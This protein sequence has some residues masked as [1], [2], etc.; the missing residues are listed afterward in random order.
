MEHFGKKIWAIADGFIP[1]KSNGPAPQMLSHD[2]LCFLNV[3]KTNAEVKV[4]IY[5]KDRPPVGPYLLKVLAERTLHQ[6]FNDLNDPEEIPR[7]TDFAALVES[8]TPLIVQQTRL[9]SRQAENTVF[10]TIAFSI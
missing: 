4:T 7:D 6:R 5:F 9:D 1:S 8:D 10:S 3:T 2:T